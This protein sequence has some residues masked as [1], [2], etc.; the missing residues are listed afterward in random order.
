[1][2]TENKD[3]RCFGINALAVFADLE[4]YVIGF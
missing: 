2:C 1:M 4:L 3:T